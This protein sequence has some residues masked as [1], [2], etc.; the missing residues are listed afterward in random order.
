MR[1]L[2]DIDVAAAPQDGQGGGEAADPR[3]CD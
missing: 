3:T 2:V 1:L